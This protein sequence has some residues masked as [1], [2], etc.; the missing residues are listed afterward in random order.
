MRR[1]RN[2]GLIAMALSTLLVLFQ[3]C[4]DYRFSD[5]QP[6]V[7][8]LSLKDVDLQTKKNQSV[9]FATTFSDGSVVGEVSFSKDTDSREIKTNGGTFTIT[10]PSKFT[11]IYTPDKSFV[12]MDEVTIFATDVYGAAVPAT[13]RV[14]V[15]NIVNL[16]QPALAVRGISCITCHSQI[17]SNVI[18]DYGAGHPW[19]FDFKSIDSYYFERVDDGHGSNGLNS[20]HLLNDSKLFVPKVALPAEFKTTFPDF[21]NL[22]SL[23]DF[24]KKR[25]EGSA[26][27]A[28]QAVE[29]EDL[30]IN[31]PTAQRLREVFGNPNQSAVYLPDTQHSPPLTGLLESADKKV[32]RINQLECDGDLFLDG[33]VVFTNAR[34]KSLNG[35]RIYA[36]GSV[37]VQGALISEP[38]GSSNDYNTQILSATS[39]W[40][41]SGKMYND[42]GNFCEIDSTT[43]LGTGWYYANRASLGCTDSANNSYKC[44][45]LNGRM[46]HTR[47]RNSFSVNVA[48]T[49]STLEALM[50]QKAWDSSNDGS[51]VVER[52]N[53]ETVLGSPL[54]DASCEA[55]GRDVD[56]TRILLA[57]PYVNSRYKG[58]FEGA[59]IAEISLMSLGDFKFVFHDV[60]KTVSIFSLL[61][62][63]ELIKAKL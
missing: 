38:I 29:V 49:V 62:S 61:E 32:F 34:V 2:I 17:A 44:D 52:F 42:Q 20:I 22:N 45:S 27:K 21:A 51:M 56:F 33:S 46:Y 8:G 30:K 60:F 31:L 9:P 57:A 58:D 50:G 15:G 48:P 14:T 13:V 39:I 19:Y 25:F 11:G 1:S 40:L 55:A 23:V 5:L 37:F 3:N 16:M 35:C 10:N 43:N 12:G 53:V 18:T 41:G 4:G 47:L 59:I 7:R 36:T 24:V 6:R 28:E 54:R 63:D 26:N